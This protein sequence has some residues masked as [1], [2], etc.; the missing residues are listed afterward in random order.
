MSDVEFHELKDG[1]LVRYDASGVLD[2]PPK[3][4]FS[5]ADTSSPSD[6]GFA[7]HTENMACNYCRESN[8]FAT[9]GT[10]SDNY[11]LVMEDSKTLH[12]IAHVDKWT[13]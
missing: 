7:V 12:H 3:I 9:F 13:T 5:E 11:Y 10:W 1:W 8:I 4:K 2:Y 6:F